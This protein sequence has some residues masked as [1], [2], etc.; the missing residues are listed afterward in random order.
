MGN[1]PNI[2]K[3][4]DSFLR[5]F[6]DVEKRAG[7][8][9]SLGR[10]RDLLPPAIFQYWDA[11]GFASFGKGVLWLVDPRAYEGILDL[12]LTDTPFETIRDE[13]SVFARN[14]FGSLYVWRKGRGYFIQIDALANAI[15]YF[16]DEDRPELSAE[17]EE[18][19]MK[20]FFAYTEKE[21]VDSDDQDEEPM[22]DRALSRL[23]PLGPDDMYGYK[24]MPMLGGSDSVE[25]LDV[26]KTQ[27]YHDI[28]VQ[29]GDVDIV[30]I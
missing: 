15:L 28:A 9:D 5:N 21:D 12:W 18:L 22:F 24:H 11:V 26:V 29:M 19:E 7:Q 1:M 6:G 4:F 27:V 13:L 14:A 25:N 16:S 2:D 23:G 30:Q 17:D 10:Y 3:Y 20:R 8:V